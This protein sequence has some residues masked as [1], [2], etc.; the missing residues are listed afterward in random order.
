[1][2]VQLFKL[3]SRKLISNS[4]VVGLLTYSFNDVTFPSARGG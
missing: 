2:K 4:Y 3:L 1:M